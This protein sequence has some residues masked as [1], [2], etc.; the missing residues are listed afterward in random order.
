MTGQ[1]SIDDFLGTLINQ[2]PSVQKKKKAPKPATSEITR[3]TRRESHERTDKQPLRKVVLE[4]LDGGK[5]LT[6]REI[7][8]EM[9]MMHVL[10][11]PARAIIQARITELVHDG[12]VEAVKKKYDAETERDVTVYK[13]V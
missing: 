1:T 9:Y 6:A 8:Q 2:Q 13:A 7:A 10:P 4:V 5:Q 3:Q 11:Y 12:K